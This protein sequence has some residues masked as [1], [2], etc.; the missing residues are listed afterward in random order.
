[1]HKNKST[2]RATLVIFSSFV[3][4]IL[5][6][7]PGKYSCGLVCQRHFVVKHNLLGHVTDNVYNDRGHC[8]TVGYLGES[9]F[10]FL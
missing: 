8:Q 2:P 7:L 10:S 4:Q 1:M 9:S 3:P 6:K 5:L